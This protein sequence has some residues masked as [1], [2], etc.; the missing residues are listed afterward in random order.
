MRLAFAKAWFKLTHR[1]MG[2]RTRYLGSDVPKDNSL[3]GPVPAVD[4]P[5]IDDNDAANLKAAILKIRPDRTATGR[6]RLGIGLHF[7]PRGSDMRGGANGA[8]HA[9]HPERLGG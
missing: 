7:F 3:A 4:H 2:P 9:L 6:N 1:D 5:L 8:R